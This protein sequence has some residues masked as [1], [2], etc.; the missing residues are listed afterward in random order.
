MR[1]DNC[2]VSRRSYG[3][4][5]LTDVVALY[6]RMGAITAMEA[7]DSYFGTVLT[8]A[9]AG[10]IAAVSIDPDRVWLDFARGR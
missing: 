10:E 7:R 2:L 3:D 4:S 9:K 6:L 1:I 5:P 8:P